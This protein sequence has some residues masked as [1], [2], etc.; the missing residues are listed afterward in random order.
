MIHM[1]YATNYITMQTLYLITL[2]NANMSNK[3]EEKY[4][5]YFSTQT[6]T[7]NN[8]K[9]IVKTHTHIYTHLHTLR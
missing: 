2:K 5:K 4:E 9:M 3:E 7:L 8:G 6:K 1:P